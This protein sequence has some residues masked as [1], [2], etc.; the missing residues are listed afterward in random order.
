VEMCST[1]NILLVLLCK[2]IN[3]RAEGEATCF[4]G[5][6]A[7]PSRVRPGSPQLP[8]PNSLEVRE[9]SWS[10][11]RHVSIYAHW[12][13]PR[14]CGPH[15]AGFYSRKNVVIDDFPKLGIAHLT[16]RRTTGE[17]FKPVLHRVF[18]RHSAPTRRGS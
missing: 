4:A 12:I 9:W 8:I 16:S 11:Q 13:L 10:R 1:W 3:V 6:M 15:D 5:V 18:E 2:Y 17:V 7:T 14:A